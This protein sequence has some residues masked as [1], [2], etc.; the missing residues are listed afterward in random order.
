[1]TTKWVVIIVYGPRKRLHRRPHCCCHR[2]PR[3]RYHFFP[4]RLC[5]R[6]RRRSCLHLPTLPDCGNHGLVDLV[7]HVLD[8]AKDRLLVD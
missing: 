2:H 4:A 8:P 3:V 1:M 6:R 5:R 7:E